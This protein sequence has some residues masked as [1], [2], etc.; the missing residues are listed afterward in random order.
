[1][2]S[3]KS[4]REFQVWSHQKGQEREKTDLLAVEEPL[5]IQLCFQDGVR[6]VAITMRTPGEDQALAA[7][8]LFSEG[9]LTHPDQILHIKHFTPP[10]AIPT[11]NTLRVTINTPL[12]D[13]AG[14]ERHFFTNS[15]C[16]VC[17]RN[18]FEQLALRCPPVVSDL[19]FTSQQ[20]LGL[21]PQLQAMQET[22]QI[23]G[24]LHASGLV[25]RAGN[26]LS[27]TED[28]GRHNAL[29]R[30]LGGLFL[31][32]QLPAR[33]HLLLVSSR[34]SFE[35]VQK[36]ITAGIPILCGLS[37]PSSL[38]VELADAFNVTLIGFL[39]GSGFNVY[40]GRERIS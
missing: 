31:A 12:P 14:L 21:L 23:T 3:S 9:F 39:R 25:D 8:F 20:I 37:A 7:G 19:Q 22:F 11:E 16:G 17:G 1:M 33:D 13:F 34:L 6:T 27:L 15:A 2:P 29:D 4:V 38:A 28:V 26:L 32:G 10:G 40:S 35:L 30:L 5:E 36:T 24:G 18:S